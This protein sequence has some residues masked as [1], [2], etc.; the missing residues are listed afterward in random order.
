M[1]VLADSMVEKAMNKTM[2]L[3]IVFTKKME[4]SSS[5]NATD[6]MADR[7]KKIPL[8]YGGRE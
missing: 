8:G 3:A 2:S 6:E 1:Y 7:Y 5:E 4:Q